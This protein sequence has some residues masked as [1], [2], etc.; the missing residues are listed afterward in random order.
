MVI[1]GDVNGDK[2]VNVNDATLIQ[3]VSADLLT[4]SAEYAKAAD[5]DGDGSI[6]IKDATLIQKYI[7]GISTGYNIGSAI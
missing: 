5:I 1:L 3:K 6:S 4:L 2:E 7:V